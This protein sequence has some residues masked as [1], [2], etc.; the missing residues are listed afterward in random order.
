MAEIS[1]RGPY[2]RAGWVGVGVLGV[3]LGHL[4]LS[5]SAPTWLLKHEQG[6]D[7]IRTEQISSG[8]KVTAEPSHRYTCGLLL[9]ASPSPLSLTVPATLCF[10][11]VPLGCLPA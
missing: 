3:N 10:S 9:Q 11:W 4:A 2:L 6:A 7:I 8:D 5:H 1:V